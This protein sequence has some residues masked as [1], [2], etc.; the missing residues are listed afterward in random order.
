[1]KTIEIAGGSAQFKTAL[2][3]SFKTL[4]CSGASTDESLDLFVFVIDP[5]PCFQTDYDALQAAYRSTAI[6]LLEKVSASLPRLEKGKGK[7]LC[8]V[9]KLSSSVNLA[10]SMDGGFERMIAAACNMAVKTLFNRLRPQ[11]YTFRLYGAGD[12]A[13]TGECGYIAEYCVRNRSLEEESAQHS[14]ENRLVLRDK[15]EVEYPY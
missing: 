13:G 7:R 14:D 10:E 4:G 15:H 9:N 11:G 8:F 2:L 1:M 12:L 5:P 6:A 3:E